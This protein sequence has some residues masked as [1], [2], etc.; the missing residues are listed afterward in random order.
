MTEPVYQESSTQKNQL[1]N[2]NSLDRAAT[3][4]KSSSS[5]LKE[6]SKIIKNTIDEHTKEEVKQIQE[7]INRLNQKVEKLMETD[8]IKDKKAKIVEAQK[9]MMNSIKEASKTFFQVRDIILQKNHLSKEEK[10]QYIDKLFHKILDKFLSKEEKE[11]FM[12]FIQA[13][14]VFLLNNPRTL[15]NDNYNIKMINM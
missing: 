13:G 10:E 2:L 4:Y 7:A 6:N 15:E 11:L 8:Y 12:K 5:T 9:N 14:P 3:L 1:V